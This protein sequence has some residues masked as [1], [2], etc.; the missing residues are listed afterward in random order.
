MMNILDMQNVCVLTSYAFVIDAKHQ[1]LKHCF[2]LS[3]E[4]QS[5]ELL[6]SKCTNIKLT[7]T[8]SFFL[9]DLSTA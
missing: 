7:N 5:I 4:A 6:H 3:Y 8:R 1:R 2:I 9:V